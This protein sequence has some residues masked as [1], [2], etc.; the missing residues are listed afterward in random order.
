VESKKSDLPGY[1]VSFSFAKL[2]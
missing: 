2:Q 1:A